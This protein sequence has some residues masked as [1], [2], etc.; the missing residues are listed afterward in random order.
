SRISKGRLSFRVHNY[1]GAD[2][3]GC[4]LVSRAYNQYNGRVPKVYRVY[5][6][7]N[8]PFI[9][10]SL[11]DRPIGE[12]VKA[13]IIAAGEL[14]IDSPEESDFI[15][16]VNTPE[17]MTQD[18]QNLSNKDITYTSHRNLREFVERAKDYIAKGKKCIMADV[19][20]INGGETE[21]IYMLDD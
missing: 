14:I 2:E 18:I 21:L 15:L 19:A 17:Q 13:H 11:E 20:F 10:P 5:S 1:P 12:S 16:M 8:G 7:V 3:V 4:T 6:S 9:I